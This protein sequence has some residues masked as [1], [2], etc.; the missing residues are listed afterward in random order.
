MDLDILYGLSTT[1]NKMNS[2]ELNFKNISE[3]FES[4]KKYDI[5]TVV[6]VG[7]EKEITEGSFGKK[8]LGV[9]ADIDNSFILNCNST[10]QPVVLKGRAKVKCR[11]PI[12]KGDEVIPDYDGTV[13]TLHANYKDKIF[14]IALENSL[15]PSNQIGIIEVIIL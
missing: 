5:G 12:L 8:A 1:F 7:G 4:D 15:K 11:G 10:G 13:C 3:I 9:I 2:K 14:A 6:R